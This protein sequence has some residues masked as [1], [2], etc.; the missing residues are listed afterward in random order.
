MGAKHAAVS[1][2]TTNIII[3]AAHFD[4][5]V[6]RKT[7]KNLGIRTDSLN[8]FEKDLL[9][10]MTEKALALIVGEIKKACPNMKLEAFADSY[11]KKQ[12]DITIDLDVDFISRLIGHEY[13]NDNVIAICDRL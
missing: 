13:K 1:E 5:A 2:D 9:P 6:V 8:V 11:T 7:G 12:S 3:E 4:Q 10:T